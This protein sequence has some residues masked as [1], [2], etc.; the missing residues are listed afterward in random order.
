MA[1]TQTRDEIITMLQAG[2]VT[3]DYTKLDGTNRVLDCTL[4]E[5]VIPVVQ[6]D[7][8]P[9]AERKVNLSN[10]VVWD[11]VAGA[12]RTVILDRINSIT[13]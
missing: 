2:D 10:I 7:K 9:N 6:S 5:S 4:Q 3:I 11:N 8:D 1:V 13:A 12:W